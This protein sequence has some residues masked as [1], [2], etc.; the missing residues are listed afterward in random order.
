MAG[1]RHGD[2]SAT[3]ALTRLRTPVRRRSRNSFASFSV[4][5]VVF[6]RPA[7]LH[8]FSQAARKF[9]IGLPARETPL[10]FREL[11]VPPF[12]LDHQHFVYPSAVGLVPVD[13]A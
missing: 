9:P 3:P 13:L 2:L 4:S 8:A 7:A 11:N 12:L 1:N 6:V 10:A 5:P